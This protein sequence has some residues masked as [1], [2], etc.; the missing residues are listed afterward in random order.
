MCITIKKNS[1]HRVQMFSLHLWESGGSQADQS[2]LFYIFPQCFIQV[3]FL[4]SFSLRFYVLSYHIFSWNQVN[5]YSHE[6]LCHLI[7]TGA[8]SAMRF[9]SININIAYSK[10]KHTRK[11]LLQHR[12]SSDIA[13]DIFRW[14]HI[15]VLEERHIPWT[16][17]SYMFNW[18]WKKLFNNLNSLILLTVINRTGVKYICFIE[19]YSAHPRKLPF[20]SF[21]KGFL[22]FY[23]V[24]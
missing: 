7:N 19:S 17:Q 8:G 20:H 24:Q 22:L 6:I 4:H 9:F 3:S 23:T 14:L 10:N 2:Q 21:F 15:L 5:F 18:F 13:Q 11:T 12:T 16:K 1:S